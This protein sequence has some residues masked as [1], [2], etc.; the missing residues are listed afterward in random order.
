MPPK[1]NK[2]GGA[3]NVGNSND[4]DD[5]NLQGSIQELSETLTESINNL[6][7][8]IETRF[9]NIDGNLTQV[10]ND[11]LHIKEH[12]IQKLLDENAS[13]RSKVSKLEGDLQQNLQKQR[14]NN[15][16]ISGIPTEVNDEELET[17]AI[18]ILTAIDCHVQPNDIQAC[19]RLPSKRGEKKTIMKFVN[20][21][22]AEM[23]LQNRKRLMEL[24]TKDLGEKF[25]GEEKIFINENLTPY[26]AN[27]AW[28][29][30]LLKRKGW[31]SGLKVF[32]GTIKISTGDS[33]EFYKIRSDEDLVD[34]FPDADLSFLDNPY[35]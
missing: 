20:R 21:K 10:N 13:L 34:F 19:H 26:F 15:I 7:V 22:N 17:T 4:A 9:N 3:G 11:L 2:K 35:I 31:L 30:R 5:N 18:S 12:L 33:N 6:R 29:C 16:E 28:K 23:A 8:T 24:Q 14:E 32:G 25:N 1:R 27:L